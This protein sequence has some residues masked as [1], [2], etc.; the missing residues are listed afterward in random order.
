MWNFQFTFNVQISIYFPNVKCSIYSAWYLKSDTNLSIYIQCEI[1]IYL[2]SGQWNFNL[3]QYQNLEFQFTSD[4]NHGISIYLES[5]LWNFNLP[6]MEFQVPL[7]PGLRTMNF[8]LPPMEFQFTS[9]QNY[10]MSIYLL[11][12]LV[13][14]NSFSFRDWGKFK[15]HSSKTEVNWHPVVLRP[16]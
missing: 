9:N 15:F 7:V 1:S 10:G 3:P 4:Q 5:E 14:W 2:G 12:N 16:R 11:W 13:N 6:T 8:N